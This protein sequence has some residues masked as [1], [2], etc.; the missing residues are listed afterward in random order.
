MK[1]DWVSLTHFRSYEE[2]EWQ[3]DHG[4][5][6]LLGPN[7]AGKTNLLEAIAY[8]SSLRSF[9]SVPDQALIADG[10]DAAVVRAGVSSGARERLVE[11][12]LPRSGPRRTQLDKTRLQKTADLLGVLRVIAFL[13]EDLDLVKRGPAYRRDLLDAVA[14]QLWSAAHH[15]QS[16]FD[17]ALRQRNAY[18]RSG[19]RDNTTLS[20]WDA[21]LA[22]AGGRVMS[23]RARVIETLSPHLETAYGD[24]AGRPER[25]SVG[26]VASWGARDGLDGAAADFTSAILESLEK[27]RNLDYDRRLTSVGPH[28]DEPVLMLDDVDTRTH[29]SQGEQRT[30]A[31][32][33]KLAAHRAVTEMIDEPPVLLLDDVFSELD[34][35]RAAALAKT[36]PADTQTLISSARPEDVP[37]EGEVWRVGDGVRR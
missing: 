13:P 9:R 27:S 21:R 19:E 24:I 10:K 8:L 16:E 34:S 1:V 14:V 3:P 17:R 22:Q 18:L 31:L 11:I 5:N 30:M 23:R 36:L 29:G 20:V 7:G 32:A 28:R 26:Y 25:A 37:V 12:E 33:I 35:Q 15:D 4:V 2:L 6:L